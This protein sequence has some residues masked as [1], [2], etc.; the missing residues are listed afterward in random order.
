MEDVFW[1]DL[2]AVRRNA[3]FLD[4]DT[5]LWAT[6]LLEVIIIDDFTRAGV[7]SPLVDRP[8]SEA[9]WTKSREE[10]CVWC[11]M[12]ALLILRKHEN[13]MEIHLVDKW[14]DTAERESIR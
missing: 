7:R 5:L 11:E 2:K 8:E 12:L 3:K 1:F 13:P 9:L 14:P 6:A 10:L 4:R